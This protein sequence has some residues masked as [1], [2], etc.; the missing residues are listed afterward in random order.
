MNTI[1]REERTYMQT[2]NNITYTVAPLLTD[3]LGTQD[4]ASDDQGF[5]MVRG[6]RPPPPSKKNCLT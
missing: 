1:Y 6:I 4:Q 5:W 3:H 2:N